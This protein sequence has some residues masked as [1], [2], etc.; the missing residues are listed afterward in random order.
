[1]ALVD[2]DSLLSKL[3]LEEKI[4][5]LAGGEVWSTAPIPEKGI[6]CVK[7]SDGPNGARGSKIKYGASAACFPAACSVASTFDMDV[8]RRIGVA[9]GE[10]SLTKGARCLL[11]PTVCIHRHPLGGRNFESFSEDPFLTGHMGIANVTGLQSTGV[12]A[13]LKHFAVNE[14]E[15][16]RLNVNAVVAERSM[17]EIYLK[18]FELII[19]NANPWAIMTSYNKIN[20]HH[21][22]SN[23]YLLKQVLRG[24]WNW[25]G[26]V[27]SDWGGTNSSADALNAG[28]DLEMP[29]P[30]RWRK[31]SVILAAIRS[32]QLTEKTI[33]ERARC[34][35][36]FLKQLKCFDN[37][38]WSE[39]GEQA[40][41]KPEHAALIREAGAKGIVLLKNQ[42]Q[43]LP[44]TREKLKGKKVALLGYA[45]EC[46]AHGGGSASVK[47]HYKVTPWDAF[48]EAFKN[49]NVEF[50]Y[51]RGAHTFR[52]LPILVDH[53]LDLTGNPGFTY[54][55]YQPGSSKPIDTI[56]G[57]D[58]SEMSLLDGLTLENVEIDLVTTFSPPE[59]AT[60]YFTLSS[61]GPAQ[62]TINGKIILEQKQNCTDAMGF[63]FGGVFIP[64]TKIHMEQG[65]K[66]KIK[67]NAA[68]PASN[69]DKDLG[70]LEGQVG[71]RLGYMSSTEYEADPLS[72]AVE[73]AKTSDYSIIFTGNDPSWETEGQDQASFY[74]PKDGSQDRL[75]AAVTAACPKT[76]VVNSTGVAVA[77]PWLA[78]VQGLLQ[79]WFPG[80]EAGNS[81]V[82][83]L[84]GAQNPEGHLTCTFPKRLE[85]CPAYGNFPGSKDATHGLQVKYEEGVFVGYRHFD[86]LSADKVNFPFGFGLSYTTFN[87]GDLAVK[88]TSG[89]YYVV[90]IKASNIGNVEGGVA[91][92]IYVGNKNPSP[93]DPVKV[94]VGFKKV[95]LEPGTSSIEEVL[96]KAR[97]FAFWD[98]EAHQW[99]VKAGEY[100]FSV[101]K[102]SA[103]LVAISTVYIEHKLYA[104]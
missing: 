68:P 45:K 25:D 86:R 29:G 42:D 70:F 41:N 46:L 64:H 58:K 84:T 63:L 38:A 37:P 54:H 19:K 43:C 92:Q 102:S 32:G 7:T 31:P 100:N 5:L 79:A 60:Y 11:A 93:K 80:Q 96:V 47:P 48:H 101:G 83:V 66:Y 71:V 82:D 78:Q 52:Q 76:I 72:E 62:L 4:S 94:L 67:I 53:V 3:T 30:S 55:I 14:Q 56:N 39:P 27:M 59:T 10:E 12:S 2:V 104:P 90:T 36:G 88:E 17:R 89:D 91:M 20:G 18:P 73:L 65:N 40:I 13:T 35:L 51:S 97:D 1:M 99:V 85:D 44:L 21:A 81:I 74:L 6:P 77:L 26:L 24:E 16:Q 8:A 50:S 9:L 98:E 33:E 49:H 61:L 103:D 22:D 87:F 95:A 23:E 69:E 75:V 15:T 28:V 34:V 57:Y